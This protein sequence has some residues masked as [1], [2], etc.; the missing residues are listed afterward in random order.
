[1]DKPEDSAARERALNVAQSFIVQAPAGSGKTELL[2]RRFIALLGVVREPEEVVAITFTRKAAAEMRARVLQAL[3]DA[4]KCRPQDPYR[5]QLWNMARAAADNNRRSNW[6]LEQYPARLRIQ[7]IDALC[8]ALTR[9]M[10]WLSRFGAPLQIRDDATELYR[11]AALETLRLL[12]SGRREWKGAVSALLEHLDNRVNRAIELLTEMLKHR[13]Q[14]LRHLGA[15]SGQSEDARR[16]RLEEAWSGVV[17]QE[18]SLALAAVP[19]ESR[20]DMLDCARYAAAQLLAADPGS[21]VTAWHQSEDFLRDTPEDLARWHGLRELLLTSAGDWRRRV[22]AKNG[23]PAI[24]AG[25]A[26]AMKDK[27]AGLLRSLSD[28]DR[29]REAL[30]RVGGLPD[31]RFDD[32]QWHVLAVLTRLLPLAAAQLNV[33]FAEKG[34]VDFAEINMRANL[35]LGTFESPTE[36]ALQ[37]DHQISHLLVDEFQDTS[38]TQFELVRRLTAGWTEGD[39]RT[40]FLVG[41]PMQSIYRFREAEVE[42]FLRVQREGIGNLKPVPL[43]LSVN[44]RSDRR[45]VE[46][47]NTTFAGRF[48]EE[49]DFGR[50]AVAYV[51]STAFVPDLA[52]AG[53]SF[54][55]LHDGSERDEAECVVELVRQKRRTKCNEKI[56]ILV[57][58]RSSL[59]EILPALEAAAIPYSGLDIE[60]LAW[61]PVVQDLLSLTRAL[62]FPADRIAWLSILR[63][64]W[65][66][67][68]LTD[69]YSLAGGGQRLCIW[70]SIQDPE[71]GARLSHDGKERLARLTGPVAGALANRGRLP[72]RRWV[73][74]L[75][76]Q[77]SGPACVDAREQL[78]ARMYFE[79]LDEYEHRSGTEYF[80]GFSRL[81]D[82]R[83]SHTEDTVDQQLQ[84]M[85]LH[86]AKGL[87]FDT[88]IIPGLH[89]HAR[90][91]EKRLLLWEEHMQ[92]GAESLLM[93]PLAEYGEKDP[94]YEY[95]RTVH[96]EKEHHET[97]RLLYVGCTRAR[98]ELHLL[99]TVNT[100]ADGE[101]GK[102]VRQSL[103]A[104][105]WHR[106]EG[107]FERAQTGQFDNFGSGAVGTRTRPLRRL[108]LDWKP[109]D[110]P[111]AVRVASDIPAS[112][113]ADEEIEFSWAGEVARH[114]GVIIHD[115]LQRMAE[116][117]M[118]TWSEDHLAA[119]VEMWRRQLLHSGVTGKEADRGSRR[120]LQALSNA[121]DDDCARWLLSSDH[122]DARNEYEISFRQAGGIRSYRIDRTFVDDDAVRW[123]VDFKSSAHEGGQLEQFL[124]RE[125]RRYQAQLEGYAEAM[126]AMEQRPIMLG[127]YFPLIRGWRQWPF[128]VP[129]ASTPPAPPSG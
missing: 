8:A 29:F 123:I 44:F 13:D 114:V 125:Q 107:E 82:E 88:V 112:E 55:A 83:W 9:Q 33:L 84:I 14:W 118:E 95:L 126:Y 116:E 78:N 92:R 75:W 67:L 46:W 26:P 72:L 77:L 43:T 71:A 90:T 97:L 2:I 50:G 34:Q 87:E 49:S 121:L 99:G 103:L 19:P 37:L 1:M 108:P 86:K 15:D 128:K 41:D 66:G 39:G 25:S 47:S 56:A 45:L 96:S 62:L 54:H 79:L 36:L 22:T 120:V 63:A 81:V 113:S 6:Q 59:R 17:Q 98:R 11:M 65:C 124:D 129:G 60:K 110:C 117:G 109:P 16:R 53:V 115:M 52:Q 89:R 93:A 58:S 5:Q 61:Q 31:A 119:M 48:P 57:R 111:A 106:V 18:L 100:R 32:G 10:P 122:P 70:D 101:P 74:N 21:K 35:A 28:N 24:K 80:T 68:T 105:L 42:L 23:F 40:L 85:T 27:V 51:A 64:P 76:L 73:E 94:H 91:K 30:Q 38:V 104:E 127:L 4:G 7:T 20:D 102:P 69:L 3:A 12:T